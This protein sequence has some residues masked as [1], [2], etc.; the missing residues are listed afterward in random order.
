MCIRPSYKNAGKDNTLIIVRK[1]TEP[2]N[3]KCR[4]FPYYVASIQ[5][6]RRYNKLK[7]FD[8]RFPDHEVTVEIAYSI[9]GIQIASM[10]LTGLKRK[11]K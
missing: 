6:R 10:H 9:H 3:D 8:Q 1:H 7:W 11:A 2:A 5:R 4:D